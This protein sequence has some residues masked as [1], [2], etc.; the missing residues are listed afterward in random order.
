M[1]IDNIETQRILLQTSLSSVFDWNEQKFVWIVLNRYHLVNCEGKRMCVAT[2]SMNE[3]FLKNREYT[4]R[5][6]KRHELS[7]K[8]PQ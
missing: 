5:Q 4:S 7:E 8:K 1:Q 3:R 6:R 2:A